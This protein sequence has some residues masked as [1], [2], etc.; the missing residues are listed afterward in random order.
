VEPSS[1]ARRERV[2]PR[3]LYFVGL[4]YCSERDERYANAVEWPCRTDLDVTFCNI[5][6]CDAGVGDTTGQNTTEHALGII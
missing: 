4:T 2:E 3:L 6:R 1:L 5:E